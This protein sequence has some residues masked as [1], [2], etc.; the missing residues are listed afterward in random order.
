MQ[1]IELQT[2]KILEDIIADFSECGNSS[3]SSSKPTVFRTG[4]RRSDAIKL[5]TMQLIDE[6][7]IRNKRTTKRDLYYM[8]NKLF[9][10]QS[11]SD[12]AIERLA[13]QLAVPR[14]ELNIYA[15]PKGF[16]IGNISFKENGTETNARN[17]VFLI[18]PMSDYT[19]TLTLQSSSKF[20]LIV[21]KDAI[22]Q[23]LADE[24]F[25][26]QQE[27][28]LITGKGYP[29]IGTLAFVSKLAEEIPDLPVLILVDADPFGIDILCQYAFGPKKRKERASLCVP[30]AQW[31]GVLPSE[32]VSMTQQVN[33]QQSFNLPIAPA[34]IQNLTAKDKQ[35]LHS[36][37]TSYSS[38]ES[39]QEEWI[40]EMQCMSQSGIKAEI[41][42]ISSLA[43][44]YLTQVYLPKKVHKLLSTS[45]I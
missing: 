28:I 5:R 22:F 26:E 36:L 41:E 27:C 19:G 33:A 40:T 13:T 7:L 44:Q 43:P 23:Q 38:S 24:K 3:T 4:F 6:L 14:A 20:I 32:I 30:R 21:E 1:A 16:A 17:S 37:I 35:K 12:T 8:D 18:N 15:S 34:G 31:V 42:L 29:D 45:E 25:Y 39:I 10:K 9:G 2:E 11:K